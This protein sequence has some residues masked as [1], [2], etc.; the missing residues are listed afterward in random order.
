MGKTSHRTGLLLVGTGL[1]FVV[2]LGFSVI[3][4][5]LNEIPPWQT[6]ERR[7][8]FDGQELSTEVLDKD[9]NVIGEISGKSRFF[10]KLEHIPLHVRQAFI[11]A[12]DSGFWRHPGISVRGII[13]AFWANLRHQRVEQGG[14]TITQQLVRALFLTR[15]RTVA[16]KLKEVVFALAIERRLEKK[17]I[18]EQY[19]NGVFLG[20]NAYGVEAAAR[21]YFGK[22]VAHISLAEAAVLAGLPRA[23]VAYAPHRF[24]KAAR[25][26]QIWVLER[27]L[28]DKAITQR[29]YE[30]SLKA[31]VK[32]VA[33]SGNTL[34][35]IGYF[36]DM[37][38]KEARKI[39]PRTALTR[40]GVRIYT[41]FDPLWHQQGIALLKR[42]VPYGRTQRQDSSPWGGWRPPYRRLEGAFFSVDAH[43]GA[44]R[45]VLGGRSYQGSEFN[46]A[47]AMARPP[48]SV[49]IV[50][51]MGLAIDKGYTLLQPGRVEWDL[52]ESDGLGR[53]SAPSIYEAFLKG[54]VISLAPVMLGIGRRA[55]SLAATQWQFLP[56][57]DPV[58]F[59]LGQEPLT[60]QQLARLYTPVAASGQYS[61]MYTIRRIESFA[62][63]VLYQ[64]KPANPVAI[65]S[66]ESALVMRTLMSHAGIEGGAG[67][68]ESEGKPK[69][70]PQAGTGAKPTPPMANLNLAAM[71]SVGPQLSDGWIA[72]IVG[73][74]HIATAWVG[75]ERGVLRLGRSRHDVIERLRTAWNQVGAAV[76]PHV[77][78]YSMNQ[79]MRVSYIPHRLE[80][81]QSKQRAPLRMIPYITG[82]ELPPRR[83][84]DKVVWK[85]G[86]ENQS[87]K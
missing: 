1:L 55:L 15:D 61:G 51:W 38:R 32:V 77:Q 45:A 2:A 69:K 66:P 75:S 8:A 72:G 54:D 22:S 7:L 68:S 60:L 31:P 3:F 56:P 82:T 52:G 24:P 49:A 35:D 14:S 37:V 9:G 86:E 21:A 47:V 33:K 62:G 44:I 58:R 48:G 36:L 18:L 46:R 83:S 20:R 43:D 17:V 6:I 64:H 65:F 13:R 19:L 84:F 73:G 27:M 11:S 78:P 50:P 12:E 79:A 30:M 85:N 67:F 23:P 87:I 39:L 40:R 81:S 10:L 76:L 34:F 53:E 41:T 57:K 4:Q 16:R 42:L 28:A 71:V 59:S 70:A 74:S 26:R 25:Q 80:N 5:W 29:D 63:E